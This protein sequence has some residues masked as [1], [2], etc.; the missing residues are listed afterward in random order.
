MTKKLSIFFISLL[1]FSLAACANSGDNG[2][3]PDPSQ[4]EEPGGDTVH[5][6]SDAWSHDE[7]KHWHVC[8]DEG[9]ESLKKDEANHIYTDS[10]VNPDF[11][12]GGYTLHTCIC[13]HSYRDNE[14]SPLEH[15]Y[16]GEWNHD[17]TKHWHA[18]TDE[19]YS[20]LV[21]GE[22]AHTFGEW[23]ITKEASTTED[24]LRVRECSVCG[25]QEQE[26]IPT[27]VPTLEYLSFTL[28]TS[29]ENEE[30]YS[31]SAGDGAY[32]QQSLVIPD[33]Y[34]GK[35][36]KE[37]YKFQNLFVTKSIYIPNSITK[38]RDYAFSGSSNLEYLTIPNSV[39][40]I[41]DGCFEKC[42]GLKKLTMP[43]AG[44]ELDTTSR[45]GD[46]LFG[47]HFTNTS[48]TKMH[49]IRVAH[50]F[51]G[52]YIYVPYSLKEVVITNG[53]RI[54]YSAFGGFEDIEKIT[55]PDS[56]T[57]IDAGAFSG[58]S[59]LREVNIPE[60]V[61][62]IGSG[63]FNMCTNLLHVDLPTGLTSIED[64]C[65]NSCVRLS[66]VVIP[67]GVTSIGETAFRYCYA[68]NKINLPS[69]LE[70]IKQNAF[71]D[72][73]GLI[74]V[75]NESNLELVIGSYTN[76]DVAHYAKSIVTSENDSRFRLYE[77]GL[78]V[79]E[80]D[81]GYRIAAD[82][83]GEDSELIIPDGINEIA[84]YAFRYDT[85]ITTVVMPA[86]VTTS[87][88]NAFNN[89]TNVSD[90]YYKGDLEQWLALGKYNEFVVPTFY[91]SSIYFLDDN[92]DYTFDDAKYSL[93]TSVVVPEGVTVIRK[94]TFA[95]FT[96]LIQVTLPAS[97]ETIESSA[98]SGCVNLV[99]IINH[100]SIE[101]VIE[102]YNYGPGDIS[103]YAKQV[104]TDVA[105]SKIRTSGDYILYSDADLNYALFYLGDDAD[106][107]VP[108]EVT[109]IGYATFAFHKE[110]ETIY[111][112]KNVTYIASGAFKGCSNL[113]E[114][115]VPFIGETIDTDEGYDTVLAALFGSESY[116]NSIVI[117]QR[118]GSIS[119]QS[120]NGYFP[121]SLEKVTVLGGK[122]KYGAFYNIDFLKEVVLGADVTSIGVEAFRS[123]AGFDSLQYQGTM[124]QW[125]EVTLGNSWRLLSS[126]NGVV[127][128]DGEI[129]F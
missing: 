90:F 124:E 96:S 83:R 94:N 97:L 84:P 40:Y 39:E 65:F 81:N 13:G 126:I 93:V 11:D 95:N 82:Y 101:I 59:N 76:G 33:T 23:D 9:Y 100:S 114:M 53:T 19:G 61:T 64:G 41:G 36:V 125:S 128:S 43:F 50:A 69:G 26:T 32:D 86:S 57:I 15:N 106:V 37:L 24:G 99:E 110:I 103:R 68:I 7:T 52:Y 46:S 45:G 58:C 73:F 1:V 104:I 62:S 54:G 98:F 3:N 17:E 91:A 71:L 72:C 6:Y 74:E 113:R 44:R 21:S 118:Y 109:A 75:V 20:D 27:L 35:P 102:E 48:M 117:S 25:Y 22:A 111:V 67:E 105:D 34:E 29:D 56:M 70:N 14:T 2:S 60:G 38:I 87:G 112:G 49:Q 10:V 77:N 31:V 88:V 119:Y 129:T 127:C 63:A 89:C 8:I 51:G 16:S 108:E 122:V 123:S 47:T 92:G 120:R 80:L 79:L 116:D 12:N 28:K 55:L 5:H 115:T 85:Q 18:C 121:A 42:A 66:G 78:Y 107:V 30:Y 4:E